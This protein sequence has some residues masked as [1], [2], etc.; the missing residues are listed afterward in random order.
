MKVLKLWTLLSIGTLSLGCQQRPSAESLS[1][2]NWLTERAINTDGSEDKV[3]RTALA[4]TSDRDLEIYTLENEQLQPLDQATYQV[5]GEFLIVRYQS[6]GKMDTSLIIQGKDY[7]D[8][9]DRKS[10]RG[11][12][13]RPMGPPIKE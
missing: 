1:G 11:K 2:T 8:L 9:L 12:R 13:Y 3:L 10:K 5:D 7:L 6:S 4:F